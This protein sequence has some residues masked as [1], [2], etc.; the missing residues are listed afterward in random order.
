[1]IIIITIIINNQNY[2]NNQPQML[3][4]KGNEPNIPLSKNVDNQ[5]MAAPTPYYFS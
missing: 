4:T 5:D 3:V 1:M 2:Y